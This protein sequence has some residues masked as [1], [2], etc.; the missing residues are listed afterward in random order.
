MGPGVPPDWWLWWSAHPF[1]GALRRDHAQSP[2]FAA[3][4]SEV[5]GGFLVSLYLAVPNLPQ[6]HPQLFLVLFS[7]FVFQRGR[8]GSSRCKNCSKGFQ[9]QVPDCLNRIHTMVSLHFAHGQRDLEFLWPPR[10]AVR[11][12]HP[13]VELRFKMETF[14]SHTCHQTCAVDYL[15]SI[16]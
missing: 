4:T 3:H 14:P 13:P 10:T 15:C 11:H 12:G 8:R 16:R 7:F 2:V 9:S 5:A 6:L 1:G